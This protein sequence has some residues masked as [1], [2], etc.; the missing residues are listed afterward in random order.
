MAYYQGRHFL[1]ALLSM[2]GNDCKVPINTK[3]AL[4]CLD[5]EYALFYTASIFVQTKYLRRLCKLY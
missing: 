5:S 4:S 1:K 3:R 2:S